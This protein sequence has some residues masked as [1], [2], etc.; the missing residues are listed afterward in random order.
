MDNPAGAAAW[1]SGESYDLYMGRWSRLVAARFLAWLGPPRGASWLEVG[2]GTGALSRTILTEAD[3]ASLLCVEP[4]EGFLAH[5]RTTLR[6]PR[7]RFE[8]GSAEALPIDSASLDVV[9]SGLVLN[10]VPDRERA[11]REMQ[12]VL[13]PGGLVGF[14]VWDYPNGGMGFIDAFWKAAA[15]IGIAEAAEAQRFPFC[16]RDGL[17][18]LCHASGLRAAACTQIQVLTEFPSFEAFWH[19]F[20]LGTGPAPAFCMN[21]P[22][23]RRAILKARLARDLGTDGTIRLPARAWAVKAAAVG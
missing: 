10:F 6:D 2:C 7:V 15:A 17:L 19:P 8:R 3:P 16:T 14:Y 11:L 23:E 22:E 13:R 12:R 1:N 20:T 18:D 9:A 21:L 5:V 4:S